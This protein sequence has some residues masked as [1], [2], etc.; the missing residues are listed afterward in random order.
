MPH[1]SLFSPKGGEQSAPHISLFLPKTESSLRLII[2]L[3]LPKTESSLRL[4]VPISPKDGEQSAQRCTRVYQEGCTHREGV[5]GYTRRGVH[6][7]WYSPGIPGGVY[8]GWYR[9]GIPGGVPRVVY[10]GYS[11]PGI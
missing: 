8:I 11:L 7:G 1:I 9:P 5:P 3:F 10:T 2:P 6:I 4:I